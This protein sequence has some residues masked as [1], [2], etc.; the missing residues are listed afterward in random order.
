MNNKKVMVLLSLMVLAAMLMSSF[1]A[2]PASGQTSVPSA[3]LNF[4]ATPGPNKVTLSWSIPVEDGGSNILNYL[5]YRSYAGS[6]YSQI[7][8]VP[9]GTLSFVD[10]TGVVGY[11]YSYYVLAVNSL[12][13]GAHS[14]LASAA[15]QTS[16]GGTGNPSY[17]LSS[18]DAILA[19]IGI[20]VV[21]L[22]IVIAFWYL[23]SK[24]KAKP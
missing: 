4:T 23:R 15:P 9:N 13:P 16:T 3:P 20:V 1:A 19:G 21:I 6:A 10:S 8:S 22:V 14:A 5:V 12:G 11:T 7:G 24:K 17:G 2:I 18:N